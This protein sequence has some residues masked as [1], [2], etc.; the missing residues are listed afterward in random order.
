MS[1]WQTI[2]S[3]PKDGTKIDVWAVWRGEAVGERIPDAEWGVAWD[4]D[5][6]TDVTGWIN[7]TGGYDGVP[8]PLDE[9]QIATHWMPRPDPPLA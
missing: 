1:E 3:A 7:P 4:H 8:A 9:E 6:E 5:R 2:D